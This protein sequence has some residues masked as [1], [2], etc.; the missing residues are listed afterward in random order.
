MWLDIVVIGTTIA[1]IL[2]I[3]SACKLIL[4]IYNE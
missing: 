4:K 3:I 2:I 1:I